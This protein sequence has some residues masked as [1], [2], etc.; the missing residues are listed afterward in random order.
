M[1]NG[2]KKKPRHS[3]SNSTAAKVGFDGGSA[4]SYM[5]FVIMG[6]SVFFF[7]VD[8][9]FLVGEKVWESTRNLFNILVIFTLVAF[10]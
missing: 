3:V 9:N 10:W 8:S 1:G 2:A 6:F 4:F 7:W 5:A